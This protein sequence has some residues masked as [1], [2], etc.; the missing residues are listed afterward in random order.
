MS[1]KVEL[2]D[3]DD[4]EDAGRHVK[5]RCEELVETYHDTIITVEVS[6][7]EV[8]ERDRWAE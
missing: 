7:D 8:G 5:V 3:I 6:V 2:E 4:A 1:E